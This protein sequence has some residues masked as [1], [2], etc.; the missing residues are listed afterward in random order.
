ARQVLEP[1]GPSRDL[2]LAY[3]RLAG[4]HGFSYEAADEQ[5]M[6][7]K[8]IRTA[9]EVDAPDMRIWASI[10]L[11]MAIAWQGDYPTGIRYL[12]QCA[13]EAL[14]RGLHNIAGNALHNLIP[15]Y[16]FNFDLDKLAA[17][18]KR[19]EDLRL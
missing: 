6:A 4:L 8:A 3:I 10:F 12:E 11:G 13:Q 1:A 18:P 17:L 15:F 19:L 16:V 5:E 14:E 2:A 9:D 7:E